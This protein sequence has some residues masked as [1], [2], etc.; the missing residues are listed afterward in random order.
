MA[1]HTPEFNP[2]GIEHKVASGALVPLGGNLPYY[3]ESSFIKKS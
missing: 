2:G 1:I 3:L